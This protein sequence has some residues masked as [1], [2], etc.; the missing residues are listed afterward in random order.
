E[1]FQERLL[2]EKLA[3]ERKNEDFVTD[4]SVFDVVTYMLMHC[5][6][7]VTNDIMR[8]VATGMDRYDYIFYCPMISFFNT[9]DDPSRLKNDFYHQAY[10]VLL[11]GLLI[12][13]YPHRII[14]LSHSDLEARVSAIV[15]TLTDKTERY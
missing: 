3:W 10:E 1:D 14:K 12:R 6:K 13:F 4:R 5:S 11:E 2:R 9:D 7:I 8:Q 15:R